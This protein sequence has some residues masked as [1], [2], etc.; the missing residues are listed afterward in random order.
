MVWSSHEA[1][2]RKPE[3]GHGSQLGSFSWANVVFVICVCNE[4]DKLLTLLAE[5]HL[6]TPSLL[7][8]FISAPLLPNGEEKPCQSSAANH[9]LCVCATLPH[10]HVR[11]CCP[12]QL[13]WCCSFSTPLAVR[14][15]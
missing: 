12:K 3:G 1:E 14:E 2:P 13:K 11:S 5:T 10:S 8:P 6:I 15:S 7:C 4:R 9:P